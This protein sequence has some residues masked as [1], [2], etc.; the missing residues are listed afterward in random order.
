[1]GNA[2]E[3]PTRLGAVSK[4]QALRDVDWLAEFL[5]VSK[6]WVYQATASGRIPCVRIGSLVRFDRDTILAWSRSNAAGPA[7]KPGPAQR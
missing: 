3:A 1:M 6:S 5:G 2:I 4:E 7:V